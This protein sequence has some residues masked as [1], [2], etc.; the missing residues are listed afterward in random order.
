LFLAK[1]GEAMGCHVVL[2]CWVRL[3]AERMAGISANGGGMLESGKISGKR[4][5][6]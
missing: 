1:Q 2:F 5:L 6:E 3:A 4:T